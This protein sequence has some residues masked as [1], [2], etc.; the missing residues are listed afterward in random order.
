[1][2][3]SNAQCV[4]VSGAAGNEVKPRAGMWGLLNGFALTAELVFERSTFDGLPH[5][6][7]L[8]KA[9]LVGPPGSLRA[10]VESLEM[11]VALVR[12]GQ[13]EFLLPG[14]GLQ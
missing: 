3:E 6:E 7:L 12:A 13:V 1:M 10:C 11:M 14:H 9:L 5:C 4:A 8:R 2:K